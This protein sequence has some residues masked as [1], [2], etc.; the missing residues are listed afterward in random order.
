VQAPLT[1]QPDANAQIPEEAAADPLPEADAGNPAEEAAQAQRAETLNAL[2]GLDIPTMG[3]G[4]LEV[5]LF[6]PAGFATWAFLNLVLALLCLIGGF[7]SAL[8]LWLNRNKGAAGARAK[9]DGEAMRAADEKLA[10]ARVGG[11]AL[12]VATGIGATVFFLLTEDLSNLMVLADSLTWISALIAAFEAATLRFAFAKA[13]RKTD[14]GAG[15][16][17]TFAK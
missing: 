3:I 14:S 12:A 4:N 5:P 9:A 17:M 10:R 15:G 2:R 1:A 6:G 11:K 7:W 8:S 16:A 13:R